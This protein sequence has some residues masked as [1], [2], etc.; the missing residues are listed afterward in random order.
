MVLLLVAFSQGVIRGLQLLSSAVSGGWSAYAAVWR[1]AVSRIPLPS[2]L[3]LIAVA[4]FTASFFE[5]IIWRLFGITKLEELWGA[6]RANP[7]QALALAVW[8][9]FSL[10]TIATFAIGYVYGLIFIK[11]RKSSTLTASHILTDIVGVTA[12]LVGL[13]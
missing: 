13:P 1:E 10:H 7:I 4:P 5:E 12:L 6:R 9:G 3:Y 11:R 2:K 8:H